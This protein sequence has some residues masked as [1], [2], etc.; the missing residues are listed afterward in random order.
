MLNTHT[1]ILSDIEIMLW[2]FMYVARTH[3]VHSTVIWAGEERKNGIYFGIR[4]S[5]SDFVH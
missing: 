5:G 2:D 4:F 1:Q 3:D